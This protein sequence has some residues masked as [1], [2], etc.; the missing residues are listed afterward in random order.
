M[1]KALFLTRYK[2]CSNL[3]LLTELCKDVGS[4]P[5]YNRPSCFHTTLIGYKHC[6]EAAAICGHRFKFRFITG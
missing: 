1:F 2:A 5:V 6:D 3:N 4:Y